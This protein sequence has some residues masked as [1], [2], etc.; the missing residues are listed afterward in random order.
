MNTYNLIIFQTLSVINYNVL[1]LL[2]PL[3][4]L[5]AVVTPQV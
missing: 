2:K 3:R 5:G 1:I 4:T